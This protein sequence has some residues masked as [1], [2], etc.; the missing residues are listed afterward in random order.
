LSG[1]EIVFEG[2]QNLP[3]T[4]QLVWVIAM[5]LS[6][7]HK[8]K[9]S[10]G[11][12]VWLIAVLI[13]PVNY[14]VLLTYANV[15]FCPQTASSL[16]SKYFPPLVIVTH[17]L[18]TLFT[19]WF[20]K[21]QSRKLIVT[22]HEIAHLLDF[23]KVPPWSRIVVN[24]P[25]L[26][27]GEILQ[28]FFWAFQRIARMIFGKRHQKVSI[29][30]KI[31]I[32]LSLLI[33]ASNWIIYACF[34]VTSWIFVFLY[35]IWFTVIGW[36]VATLAW[37]PPDEFRAVNEVLWAIF[38]SGQAIV[39]SIFSTVMV[40]GMLTYTTMIPNMTEAGLFSNL[41]P[42]SALLLRSEVYIGWGFLFMILGGLGHIVLMTSIV[43]MY[44]GWKPW[45]ARLDPL[46]EDG[47]GGL[48]GLGELIERNATGLAVPASGIIISWLLVH[49]VK[50]VI[51]PLYILIAACITVLVMFS[52]LLPFS[53]LRNQTRQIKRNWL[54]CLRSVELA[55]R[56]L[57]ME[58]IHLQSEGVGGSRFRRI[59]ARELRELEDELVSHQRAREA[60]QN[61]REI[62]MSVGSFT[63]V[64]S[65]SLSPLLTVA[66]RFALYP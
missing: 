58:Y 42:L 17:F 64:L 33:A 26:T 51:P 45:L 29:S 24:R 22:I 39:L 11:V 63:T 19:A 54:E 31:T 44:V 5:L 40:V 50:E 15:W 60:I 38:D 66:L 18:V 12:F 8:K 1:L 6:L 16:Y 48:R 28:R 47:C 43:V 9:L 30:R 14:G 61:M 36:L 20:V 10:Y 53:L 3:I 21:T 13:F 34:P 62:P 4:K 25:T 56:G 27:G 65:I 46:H 32:A 2:F 52:Y 7:G 23:P 35:L 59:S 55:R 37:H 41:S 57:D 49:P